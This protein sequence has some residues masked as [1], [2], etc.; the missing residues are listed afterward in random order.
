L[1]LLLLLCICGC[2]S[3]RLLLQTCTAATCHYLLLLSDYTQTHL[4][5]MPC[6]ALIYKDSLSPG[7]VLVEPG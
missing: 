3:C 6:A 2:C 5:A 1:L 7:L 4:H